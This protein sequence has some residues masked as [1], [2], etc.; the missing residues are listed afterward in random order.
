M[1]GLGGP[2]GEHRIAALVFRVRQQELEF[3]HFVAAEGDPAQIVPFEID[4]PPVLGADGFEQ[5]AGRGIQPQGELWQILGFFHGVY[6]FRRRSGTFAVLIS[7]SLSN[8]R[9]KSKPFIQNR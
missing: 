9:G 2:G 1:V 3:S 8:F 7:D 6:S 4:P 5:I